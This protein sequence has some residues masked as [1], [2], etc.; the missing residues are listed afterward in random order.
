MGCYEQRSE[1]RTLALFARGMTERPQPRAGRA[2]KEGSEGANVAASEASATG[3]TER[4]P[5][6]GWVFSPGYRGEVYGGAD[7]AQHFFSKI[8]TLWVESKKPW[9][10][11][12]VAEGRGQGRSRKG[13]KPSS[14][15]L[16][17][18]GPGGDEK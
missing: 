14:K 11:Q 15:K 17:L 6:G 8:G 3:V 9:I 10:P 13:A 1:G 5:H 16:G 7:R 18:G 2:G 12:A 4:G